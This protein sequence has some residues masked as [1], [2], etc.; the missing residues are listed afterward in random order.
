M[1]ANNNNDDGN[2]RHSTPT[3][4]AEA[5]AAYEHSPGSS[6]E[7]ANFL[8]EMLGCFRQLQIGVQELGTKMVTMETNLRREIR[9]QIADLRTTTEVLGAAATD[10][11]NAAEHAEADVA[12]A[13]ADLRRNGII[14]PPDPDRDSEPEVPHP[15]TDRAPIEAGITD[16]TE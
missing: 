14:P 9:D 13:V 2:H 7:L 8:R 11:R 16:D 1:S 4:A 6:P 10:A 5:L 12:S 15:N 3:K